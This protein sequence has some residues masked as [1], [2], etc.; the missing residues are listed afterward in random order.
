LTSFK[1]STARVVNRT[2]IKLD[3]RHTDIWA[4]AHKKTD[5]GR[6]RDR[7]GDNPSPSAARNPDA[8][9]GKWFRL[10]REI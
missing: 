2:D 8:R 3:G 10:Y 9:L 5:Q 7:P 1:K 4:E 6:I